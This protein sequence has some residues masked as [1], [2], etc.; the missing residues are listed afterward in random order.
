MK[1]LSD[2]KFS[3]VNSALDNLIQLIGSGTQNHQDTS[4]PKPPHTFTA[5]CTPWSFGLKIAI[6]Q[7]P[8]HIQR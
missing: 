6:K 2:W 5:S 7:S 1:F 4:N 3:Q 8:E